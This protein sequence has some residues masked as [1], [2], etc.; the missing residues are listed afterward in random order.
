MKGRSFGQVIKIILEVILVMTLISSVFGCGNK[1]PQGTA[2]PAGLPPAFT[3]ELPE[4]PGELIGV[5]KEYSAGSMEWGTE[6]DIDINA[7]EIVSC[8]YWDRE[9]DMSE[10][11]R[12][13]HVPI[14][15]AQWT[16]VK[17]AVMDLWGS[18]EVIPESVLNKKPDPNIQVLDGGG[19]DRWWLTWKTA[20]GT[21]KIRYYGP[22][23]RRIVTLD[24]ILREIADP[25]GRKIEWYDPPYANGA[26]YRND[27]SGFSFQCSR[28]DE[29]DNGYRLIVYFEGIGGYSIDG[30]AE[31][32]FWEKV[33]PAFAWLDVSKF[34][35]GSYNDKIALSL[36]YSD[37]S[38]KTLKLDKSSADIIEPY[39]RSLAKEY[40]ENK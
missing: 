12:K 38:Q 28:W 35:D 6:F 22:S 27:K 16:D 14:T 15:E 24:E 31:D 8:A 36:Y 13:E 11:T 23:D 20:D 7:E 39:L 3:P 9:G 4:I 40:A 5:T 1:T 26:Y 29:G 33:W 17:K 19:Y 18:W 34:Q 30:H 37:G 10:M 2:D 21:E 25:K 32:A